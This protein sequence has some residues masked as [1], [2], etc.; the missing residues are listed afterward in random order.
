MRTRT[1]AIF[2]LA[3]MLAVGLSGCTA[4]DTPGPTTPTATETTVTTTDTTATTTTTALPSNETARE[5]AIDAEE[6]RVEN[7]LANASNVS[8]SA[9][10][11]GRVEATVLDR[12]GG[13]VEVHVVMSYSYEY[14]CGDRAGA[15]D[16]QTTEAI[17][18]VTDEETRLIE[19]VKGVR[20]IC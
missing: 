11:Y 10:A 16:G 14:G 1:G 19:V 5:R 13:R 3:V 8:G 7:L 6:A 17:Y 4:A 20:L 2:G 15:V 9:G 12:D 18:R